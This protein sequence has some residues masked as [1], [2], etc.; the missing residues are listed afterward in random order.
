MQNKRAQLSRNRAAEAPES[1]CPERSIVPVGSCLHDVA[2]VAFCHVTRPRLRRIRNSFSRVLQP[3]G[4]VAHGHT[5]GL[6]LRRMRL[7]GEH[8][9]RTGCSQGQDP[10]LWSVQCQPCGAPSPTSEATKTSPQSPQKYGSELV[11]LP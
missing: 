6:L 11:E 1:V 9:I 10:C 8:F 5:H 4:A 7:V 3:C 2:I